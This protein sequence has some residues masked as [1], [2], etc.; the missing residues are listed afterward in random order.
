MVHIRIATALQSMP[1]AERS[2]GLAE[3]ME[4]MA[5]PLDA[6]A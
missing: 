2:L 5:A 4:E 6:A 1:D 3:H